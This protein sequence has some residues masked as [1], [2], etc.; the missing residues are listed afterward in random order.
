[1]ASKGNSPLGIQ[2]SLNDSKDIEED[3]EEALIPGQSSDDPS[4]SMKNEEIVYKICC[5]PVH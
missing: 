5:V 1:M 2:Q 3:N 4:E